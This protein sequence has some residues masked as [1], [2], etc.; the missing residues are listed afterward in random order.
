MEVSPPEPL[1][2]S[3]RVTDFVEEPQ[4]EAARQDAFTA[5]ELEALLVLHG[6]AR[7]DAYVL[8]R[9]AVECEAPDMRGG[10]GSKALAH[11][12]GDDNLAHGPFQIRIDAHPNLHAIY[13]LDSKEGASRAAVEVWKMQGLN[14]WSC[15]R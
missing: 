5:E 3:A 4:V 12:R 13:D 1:V 14:A 8:S 2:I 6:M 10:G 9:A 11:A 15:V 7:K